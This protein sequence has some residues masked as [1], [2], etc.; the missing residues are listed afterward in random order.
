M[1]NRNKQILI[2]A[3]VVFANRDGKMLWFVVKHEDSGWEIPKTAVRRGESSVRASIRAMGE[4]GGMRAKV[5][6]EVGRSGGSTSVGGRIVP[7]KTIYYLMQQRGESEVLGFV[8]YDWQDYSKAV[9]KL[10]SK[11]DQNMLE[12]ARAMAKEILKKQ[13]KDGVEEDEDFFEQESEPD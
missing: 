1:N 5:L 12:K 11:K 2:S 6:E 4:Q 8:E 7:Q 13:K 10:E 9:K 3:S